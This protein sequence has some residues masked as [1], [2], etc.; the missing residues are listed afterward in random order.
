MPLSPEAR[1]HIEALLAKHR[2]NLRIL[3]IQASDY[4]PANIPLHI[5]NSMTSEQAAI[6]HY[7]AQL[8][9]AAPV[10]PTAP[11]AAPAVSGTV[12]NQAGQQVGTQYNAAG[13]QTIHTTHQSGGINFGSAQIGSIG[14]VSTN[15]QPVAP[16]HMYHVSEGGKVVS[17]DTFN[18][19]GNFSGAI[20][21]IKNTLTNTIQTVNGMGQATPD[22]KQELTQLLAELQAA[23]ATVPA[24]H[25]EAAEAMADTAKELIEKAAKDKPNKTTIQ[26]T[27]DGLKAAATN[28]AAVLPTII[29]IAGQI[30]QGVQKLIGG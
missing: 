8:T 20:L 15:D 6:D 25:T 4:G 5:V 22:Q 14:S 2:R 23:L 26:I 7:E 17:G 12:F 1:A 3:E 27:A 29:P 10:A 21:N 28:L 16:Q 19:S 30:A 24:E 18:M 9:E 13:D 11:P